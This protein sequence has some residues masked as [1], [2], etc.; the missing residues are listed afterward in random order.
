MATRKIRKHYVTVLAAVLA[1]GPAWAGMNVTVD[2]GQVWQISK[3]GADTQGVLQIHNAGDSTDTLTGW[4]CSI[5]AST[6][7]LDAS[8]A[9][10][11]QLIIQPGQT[12]SLHLR[13]ADAHYVISTG[14]IVPCALTFAGV[15]DV[16][17]YLNGVAAPE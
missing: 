14:S 5:A 16:G 12:T 8:G 6:T 11:S 10:I 13:L 17:V 15:G 3:A 7:L 4:N 9:P 1:A 2:G